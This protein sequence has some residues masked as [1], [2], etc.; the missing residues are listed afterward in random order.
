MAGTSPGSVHLSEWPSWR[1]G[2]PTDLQTQGVES[3]AEG[4]ENIQVTR[5]VDSSPGPHLPGRDQA[6]AREALSREDEGPEGGGQ[7]RCPQDAPL[8]RTE[9]LG[10]SRPVPCCPPLW[11]LPASSVLQSRSACVNTHAR[12]ASPSALSSMVMST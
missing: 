7:G 9:A 11:A 1:K 8:L 3:L 6:R 4:Q 10:L 2:G 5:K 12:E